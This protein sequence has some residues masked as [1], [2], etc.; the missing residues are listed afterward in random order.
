MG[1]LFSDAESVEEIALELIPNYHPELATA[2]FRFLFKEKAS[3]KSGK[4]VLGSVSKCN[5]RL[6]YLVEADFIIEVP[7]DVWNTLDHTKRHAL[8]DHLLERCTGVENE[9]TGTMEWG[10][11]DPDVHEFSSILR[12]YGAWTDALNDFASVAKTISLD[13]MED[14]SDIA[15]TL[16]QQSL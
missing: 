8:I 2:K 4:P 6:N 14:T 1:Q 7:L 15:E 12:R 3:K 10:T 9:K 11:R 13:F 16:V 5:D